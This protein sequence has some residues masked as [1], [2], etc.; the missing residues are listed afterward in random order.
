MIKLFTLLTQFCCVITLLLVLLADHYI[1]QGGLLVYIL[2]PL[3]T[4]FMALPHMVDHYFIETD[5]K[6]ELSCIQLKQD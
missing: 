2:L 3:A 6:D 5:N 4:L 1:K